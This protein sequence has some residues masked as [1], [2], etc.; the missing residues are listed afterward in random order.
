M[1]PNSFSV[2]RRVASKEVTL[3]FSSPIAYL[4]LAVFAAVS[5]FVFF[6]GESF[7][8]RNIADVRPLFEWMPVLLIFLC[9]ALTMRLWSEERRS[10]T[11]EHI[12]TQPAPLWSFVV[13]KFAGCLFLL[14]I[15]L[16][17]T[18]PLPVT[19][20][21]L[22]D[23]DW[24]PVWAG[25]LAAFF[26]GAAY[27]AVGLFVSARSNNQIVSMIASVS[28]CG[29]LYLLGAPAIT[30][31]FGN[32]LGEWMRL[33]GTGSRFDSI[34]RGV[35]D[36][37]D[38]YYYISLVLV[39][40]A[41]NTLF[42][43]RERWTRVQA[44]PRHKGWL[45]ATLLLVGNAVVANLWLGQINKLRVDTTAGNQYSISGATQTY[46]NQLQEPLLIRGYFSGKTHPLLSPLV[47]RVRDLIKE[48]E[49]AGGGKVVSEFIDPL[50]NPELE[51]EANQLYGI[52]PVPF[53]VADRYQSSIVS[54]YFNV[55]VQYGDEHEVLGFRELIDVNV[56]P[57][58]EPDVRLRNPEHDLTSA[59][60]K[61]LQT[62][63]SG[64]NL[65][66]NVK[67]ALQLNAYI[68]AQDK[69]PADLVQF[70]HVVTGVANQ[71][72]E[73]SGGRFSFQVIE[74]EANGG[75]VAQV[76]AEDYGLQPMSAN[77]FDNNRF[78]YYLL[79]E[80]D[81]QAMQIP[82]EDLSE[83][84]FER[85]LK[86]GIKRF[87]NSFTKTVAVVAPK[88]Q[89][90]QFGMAP[91]EYFQLQEILN[92]DYNVVE[93]DLS[94]GSVSGEVD[95]LM[96][97]APVGLDERA[98]FA[99]DQFLMQ[100]GTVIAATS[101]K[102]VTLGQQ[103]IDLA[104]KDSGIESWLAHHGV[105][106]EE[107]IVMDP[108][109]TAFPAPVT[110]QVGNM[111]LQEM[112]MINYPYF[113]DIRADGLSRDNIMTS[114]LPQLTMAWASPININNG[115]AM[116]ISAT[117]LVQ[118]SAGA[119]LSESID[120]MPKVS[121]SGRVVYE[122]EGEQKRYSLGVMLEGKFSSFFADRD[123]P[124]LSAPEKNGLDTAVDV[125]NGEAP[126]EPE[127]SPVFSG[128]I[129]H[130][131]SAARLIVFSSNDFLRDTVVQMSGS[132][133]GSNSLSAFQLMAN[134]VDFS[135]EDTAL[136]QIRSRG[137]FNRT[138]MPMEIRTR[139]FWEYLNYALAALAIAVVAFVYR[140]ISL[141]RRERYR[142]FVA[143]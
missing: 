59:I 109:N 7:F 100:G 73:E 89:M 104:D 24:G 44:R 5:L 72:V 29:L 30:D 2:M 23:L 85:N 128:V 76:L 65:F 115:N 34:T 17:I 9:S 27:L 47:P 15:A 97:A 33:L 139:W 25:Y 28:V 42:L 130:S 3:F 77:L 116:D 91:S 56:K 55:L 21:L 82:L 119:W 118:S 22:G 141:V 14:V 124:L 19:V 38:I 75:T 96:L 80:Q 43:E 110:R 13:G 123:S 64:G 112:R 99:V 26:L 50:R 143:D 92:S 79:V 93:E 137:H 105:E 49:I 12:L 40:L 18:L 108:Q 95:L 121:E 87:A 60:K 101:P 39:F 37:R 4:F 129:K 63:Q 111:R 136:T 32:T 69:L 94:D 1:R 48:Y 83:A 41:L 35:I 103:R 142:K 57:N 61:V 134:A 84:A 114:G 117:T 45:F 71:F 126:A 74:P 10:G 127:P 78:Y 52:E 51:E 138:L 135:L 68:S 36:L 16:L 131:P 62:Y 102:T 31:F 20:S 46:L 120:I 90:T 125:A 133:S 70:Q 98:V 122:P 140:R 11:L 53:Q 8:A 81:S 107:K 88:G 58:M 106:I 54:S 86:A 67:G 113:I 132:S 66:S 6:W